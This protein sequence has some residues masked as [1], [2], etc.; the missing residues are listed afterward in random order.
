MIVTVPAPLDPRPVPIDP[1]GERVRTRIAR[2][3]TILG[4]RFSFRV[5]SLDLLPLVD[6]AYA[7]LHALKLWTPVP[8][9][10][11]S[12]RLVDGPSFGGAAAPPAL[13]SF[14]GAGQFCGAID[15]ANLAT[16]CPH[17]RQGL[18]TVSRELLGYPYHARYELLEFAVYTLASRALGLAPL[19]AGCVGLQGR[20]C[21]LLGESGAGKSTLALH[22]MM[23]GLEILTEDASFIQADS[24]RAIG[25]SN[26]LH[27]RGDA[28][29]WVDEPALAAEIAKAPTIRRRSGVE[30]FELDLRG[31]LCRTARAPMR[32]AALVFVSREPPAIAGDDLVP[33]GRRD[34][35]SRLRAGQLYASGLPGWAALERRLAELPAFELRRSKHPRDAAQALHQWLARSSNAPAR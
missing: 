12:L 21:L 14:G 4:G 26:F 24:L 31:A 27:L 8:S 1:F 17:T 28:T 3:A 2:R 13:R 20:G 15:A 32:V 16:L 35:R 34:V 19:H 10:D 11:V 6:A 25:V 9:F 7:G 23:Q 29:A 33:L 18:V 22:C 5:D 30:K